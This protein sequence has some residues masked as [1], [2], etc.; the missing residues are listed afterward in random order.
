MNEK[1]RLL[2][3]SGDVNS[4]WEHSV[5]ISMEL[6]IQDLFGRLINSLK[7][8]YPDTNPQN[9]LDILTLWEQESNNLLYPTHDLDEVEKSYFK[10]RVNLSEGFRYYSLGKDICE[11]EGDFIQA[12]F[13]FENASNHLEKFNIQLAQLKY[14]L[15]VKPDMDHSSKFKNNNK[16][17]ILKESTKFIY[18]L[19]KSN[20]NLKPKQI[21]E[22]TKDCHNSEVGNMDVRTLSNKISQARKLYKK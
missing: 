2:V 7:K 16:K 8:I 10:C 6:K 3:E 9:I 22:L 19:V 4:K 11:L 18:G 12:N 21:I 5:K 17:G 1:L 14:Q 13:N 20:P 15:K